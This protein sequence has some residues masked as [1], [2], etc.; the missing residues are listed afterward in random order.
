M[1]SDAKHARLHTLNRHL[2]TE[3]ARAQ[4]SRALFEVVL[5]GL[6]L[7]PCRL[8]ASADR[9]WLRGAI[10]MPIHEATTVA[11]DVLAWRM[12]RILD[13]APQPLRERF[14]RSHAEELS[15]G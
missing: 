9:D 8:P 5:D 3:Y 15:W 13:G 14:D 6:E 11:L 10:A 7:D 1:T 2:G 4:V 12:E